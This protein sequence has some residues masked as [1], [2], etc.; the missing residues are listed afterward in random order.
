MG[1]VLTLRSSGPCQWLLWDGGL[2]IYRCG[3]LAATDPAALPPDAPAWRRGLKARLYR[4][5]RR[6]I[7]AG[8]ACD[9]SMDDP[10][11][12]DPATDPRR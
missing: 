12:P 6:W 8:T 3:V 2:K 5:A 9:C 10:P 4:A 11:A 1:A 7:A